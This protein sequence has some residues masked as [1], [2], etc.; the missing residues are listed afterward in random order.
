[1]SIICGTDLSARSADALVVARALAAQRGEREVILV[2]V[3]ADEA[4][5]ERARGALDAQAAA[6]PG[7]IAVRAELVVGDPEERLISFAETEGSDLIVISASSKPARLLELG[8]TAEKVIVAARTPVL[9]VRDPKPWLAFTAGERPLRV[10]L[11]IDDSVACDLG[12]Q[13]TQALRQRGP[14]DVVLGAIYYPD[15]AAEHYGVHTGAIVDRDPEIEKL[16]T[17]DLINRF[18]GGSGVTARAQR[19][20]GRIGDHVI[21]L[22]NDAGVDAIIIGTG[23]K[24]GLGRLGSVSSVVV[25]AATQSVVCVP[26]N[27]N[28]PT[29]IVPRLSSALVATD[30]SAFANRAVP[31]AFALTDE[32]GSVR[33]AH[34]VD[35]DAEVDENELQRQLLALVPASATREVTAHVVRGDDAAK[36][37]A[38]AAARLGCDAICIASHGRSG[39]SRALVGSVADK[40]IRATRKPVLV[41]R[42]G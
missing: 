38:Q 4:H 28:V 17:R 36:A 6:H 18:N 13:W 35:E 33:I 21:E 22:A 8:T 39:I 30:L 5:A 19:G 2:H 27:A 10:L 32:G 41:L 26:P 15:D 16:I 20:L 9:V 11:G 29:I 23:Q 31:F 14:V 24:T 12:M 1:M 34:V 40:V 37:I 25:H 7:G 3:A 42:P